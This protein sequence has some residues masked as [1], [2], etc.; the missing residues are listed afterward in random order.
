VFTVARKG[1]GQPPGG[2]A[3]SPSGA[4]GI[5]DI[6]HSLVRLAPAK[7]GRYFG[8][9]M[10]AGQIYTIAGGGPRGH[11]GEGGLA[12]KAA[13][14]RLTGLAFDRAGSAVVATANRIRVVAGR[15]GVFYGQS[16]QAGHIYTIAGTG[17]YGGSGDGGLART[18]KVASPSGITIDPHGNIVVCVR[19]PATDPE[20]GRIRIIAEQ[21]GTFYGRAMTAG[22]IYPLSPLSADSLAVDAHGNVLLSTDVFGQLDR[23]EVIAEHTGTFYGHPMTAGQ[24]YVVAGGGRNLGSGE[25]A[26]LAAINPADVVI[27]RAGNLVIGD[28]GDLTKVLGRVL[29]V[30]VR[31]G[32]FY[33]QKMTAGHIYRLAG[34]RGGGLGDGG[35]AAGARVDNPFGVAIAPSGAILVAD[36]T[37]IREIHS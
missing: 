1:E 7:A 32:A 25:L 9:R 14:S 24:A 23:V 17:A 33:G 2:I 19:G 30:A 37:R 28:L 36:G 29:V 26:T 35:P 27:D 11:P 8:R 3:V 4:I 18:A 15:S 13:T 20:D 21:S 16:M 22:H 6:A 34:N 10:D 12:T 5:A 31:S